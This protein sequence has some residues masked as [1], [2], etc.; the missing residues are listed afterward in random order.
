MRFLL[1]AWGVGPVSIPSFSERRGR[2][3]LLSD[4]G[5]HGR[6]LQ[7]G[8]FETGSSVGYAFGIARFDYRG[9]RAPS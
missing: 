8:R 7:N 2:K 5:N 6:T 1:F 4:R 3:V 9:P